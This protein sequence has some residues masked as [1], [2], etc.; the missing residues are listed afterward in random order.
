LWGIKGLGFD[1][2]STIRLYIATGENWRADTEHETGMDAD[3]P[4]FSVA[5]SMVLSRTFPLPGQRRQRH[6][7][8][9]IFV[10]NSPTDIFVD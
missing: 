10:K 8:E 4:L 2:D 9:V 3:K 7:I 6:G 1:I 5:T